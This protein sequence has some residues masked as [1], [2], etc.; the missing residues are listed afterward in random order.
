MP[1]GWWKGDP[2]GDAR[3]GAPR[4]AAQSEVTVPAGQLMTANGA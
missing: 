4:R 2:V 1:A 3:S